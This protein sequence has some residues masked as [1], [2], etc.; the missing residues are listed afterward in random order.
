[1]FFLSKII[2][3]CDASLDFSPPKQQT[4]PAMQKIRIFDF[5]AAA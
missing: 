2:P 3:A 1:M 5:S 4:G